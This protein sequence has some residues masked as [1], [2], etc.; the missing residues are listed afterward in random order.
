[1]DFDTMVIVMPVVFVSFMILMMICACYRR[2]QVLRRMEEM[3]ELGGYNQGMH[4][5]GNSGFHHQP[6]SSDGFPSS[7]GHNIHNHD[8]LHHIHNHDHLHHIHN[9]HGFHDPHFPHHSPD[10][11]SYAP[12]P[13]SAPAFSSSGDT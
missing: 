1:M 4:N 8:H 3:R 11:P 12:P 9:H 7:H 2:H 10:I 5:H 13:C 6:F